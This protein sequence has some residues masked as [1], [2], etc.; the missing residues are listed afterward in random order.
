MTHIYYI[1]GI[2]YLIREFIDLITPV[3]YVRKME[4]LHKFA[5]EIKDKND[6]EVIQYRNVSSDLKSGMW[7]V[8]VSALAIAWVALGLLTANWIIFATFLIFAFLIYSPLARLV[9]KFFGFGKAYVALHI[10]GTIVDI[11]LVGFAIINQYHLKIDL[12]KLF[13]N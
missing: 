7:N 10:F 6:D 13:F 4:K 1:F 9:R 12:F 8:I 3:A 2:F 11:L 5:E